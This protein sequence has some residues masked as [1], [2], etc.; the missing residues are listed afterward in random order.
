M[1]LGSQGYRRSLFVPPWWVTV[2]VSRCA[3]AGAGAGAGADAGASAG[4]GAVAG[5]G[6]GEVLVAGAGAH[7]GDGAFAGAGTGVVAHALTF[8]LQLA[9]N[10][11]FASGYSETKNCSCI[12]LRSDFPFIG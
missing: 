10:S 8:L 9:R 7:A 11:L 12:V 5:A 3:S 6:A 4:A 1:I 2:F